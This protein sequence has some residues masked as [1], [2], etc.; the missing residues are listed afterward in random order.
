MHMMMRLLLS[1]LG[2]SILLNALC[3]DAAAT[4]TAVKSRQSNVGSSSCAYEYQQA[5][6][7]YQNCINSI[8]TSN[9]TCIPSCDCCR[10]SRDR[11]A[12]LCCDKFETAASLY[13]CGSGCVE[14]ASRSVSQGCS[15]GS[16]GK[17]RNT[18]GPFNCGKDS[19]SISDSSSSGSKS[20]SY[21][22]YPVPVIGLL[23]LA[24]IFL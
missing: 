9:L 13:E 2:V 14:S 5:V 4:T 10:E 17:K 22:W 8:D 11:A 15:S 7:S 18:S 20:V 23:V 12:V 6:Q 3:T 1:V 24:A 21:A 19:D 16:S